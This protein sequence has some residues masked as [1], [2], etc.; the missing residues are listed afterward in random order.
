VAAFRTLGVTKRQRLTMVAIGR[1]HFFMKSSCRSVE[2]TIFAALRVVS[3]AFKWVSPLHGQTPPV[4]GQ[5]IDATEQWGIHLT[6]TEPV[7]S[8]GRTNR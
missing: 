5:F 3:N 1:P 6:I 8:P 7:E 2:Q 4:P